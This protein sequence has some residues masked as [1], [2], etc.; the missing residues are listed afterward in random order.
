MSPCQIFISYSRKANLELAEK[1]A[2]SLEKKGYSVFLD[3][4]S[5]PVGGAFSELIFSAIDSCKIFIVLLSKTTIK[6]NWVSK[7]VQHALELARVD[8]IYIIPIISDDSS[9]TDYVPDFFTKE[10]IDSNISF[11]KY[12]NSDEELVKQVVKAIIVQQVYPSIN[13]NESIEVMEMVSGQVL[14]LPKFIRKITNECKNCERFLHPD[15]SEICCPF[16]YTTNNISDE[17]RFDN[18]AYDVA[19]KY[20]KDI[21]DDTSDQ[22]IQKMYYDTYESA[23]KKAKQELIMAVGE[24]HIGCDNLLP[25]YKQRETLAR[26]YESLH[27]LSR[28]IYQKDLYAL[29][30]EIAH[31][32]NSFDENAK[33]ILNKYGISDLPIFITDQINRIWYSKEWR[34]HYLIQ[35][36]GYT[37]LAELIIHCLCSLTRSIEVVIEHKR[38]CI[39]CVYPITLLWWLVRENSSLLT[40][41]L[42]FRSPIEER[43]KVINALDTFI[44]SFEN[45]KNHERDI[46]SRVKIMKVLRFNRIDYPEE[47]QSKAT[48]LLSLPSTDF[49]WVELV[50]EREGFSS[51]GI[52]EVYLAK[53]KLNQYQNPVHASNIYLAQ[54]ANE[55]L[56]CFLDTDKDDCEQDFDDVF[57]NDNDSF[58]H[59]LA[60]EYL[61]PLLKH[62]RQIK[63]S[64]TETPNMIEPHFCIP[65]IISLFDSKY[66]GGDI[67]EKEYY[68]DNPN[69]LDYTE[70]VFNEPFS[71]E[72]IDGCEALEKGK[73]KKGISLLMSAVN[74]GELAPTIYLANYYAFSNNPSYE[75]AISLYKSAISMGARFCIIRVAQCYERIKQYNTALWWYLLVDESEVEDKEYLSLRIGTCYHHL[76]DIDSCK[77]YYNKAGTMGQVAY[78]KLEL[79]TDSRSLDS[80]SDSKLKDDAFKKAMEKLIDEAGLRLGFFGDLHQYFTIPGSNK[81]IDFKGKEIEELRRGAEENDP[82]AQYRLGLYE[83]EAYVSSD[84]FINKALRRIKLAANQGSPYALCLMGVYTERFMLNPKAAKEY[85]NKAFD[86]YYPSPFPEITQIKP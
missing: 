9:E 36:G 83:L 15:D 24:M 16:F 81:V 43:E 12:E 70:A 57:Y 23:R 13:A 3:R 29:S 21:E 8:R 10:D 55:R 69:Y 25:C 44:N 60:I 61:D 33:I 34:I 77:K 7:E 64:L 66:A 5:I 11:Y 86:A 31:V 41:T 22:H 84:S 54:C 27:L 53:A 74:N 46:P 56:F 73:Q 62:C 52:Q 79:Y 65:E 49:I 72:F 30:E 6:S 47:M 85:Y 20:K 39:E 4:S 76:N 51:E 38:S 82:H 63:R 80:E 42:L 18:K 26:L 59:G 71:K 78:Y 28:P 17:K 50:D 2:S 58:Y 32:N 37:S 45:L 14:N 67:W 68:G 75:K 40:K 1:L 35:K 19:R 48:C